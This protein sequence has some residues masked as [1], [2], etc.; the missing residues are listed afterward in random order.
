MSFETFF[1]LHSGNQYLSI[2]SMYNVPLFM[3]VHL[4]MRLLFLLH[5]TLLPHTVQ[6][7]MSQDDVISLNMYEYFVELLFVTK[8]SSNNEQ[9]HC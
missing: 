4:L 5:L 6:Q 3:L 2:S 7:G 8:I 1:F 9:N